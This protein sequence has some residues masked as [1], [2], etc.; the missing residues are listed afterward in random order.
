META[1]SWSFSTG[2]LAPSERAAALHSLRE[3]G[4]LPLEPLPGWQAHADLE[5]WSLPGIR[6]LLGTLGGLRQIGRSNSLAVGD[7]VFLGVNLTGVSTIGHLGRELTLQSGDA[8]LLSCAEGFEAHRPTPMH[9]LGLRMPHKALAPLAANLDDA[10]MRLIPSRS[11]SLRLLTN[12]LRLIGTEPTLDFPELGRAKAA[13]V[14]DLLA[15]SIGASRDA[16]AAA[17]DRVVR[18]ARL[19]AIKA[20][21]VRNLG[22]C[23][24][25]VSVVAARQGVTPRYIHKLFASEGVTFSEFVLIRRLAVAHR[26][27]TDRRLAWRSIASVAFDSG[28]ADLSYFNRTFKRTYNATPSEVRSQASG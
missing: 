10:V 21:V 18:A 25:T 9:F 8:V 13:H 5:M 22:D 12:Y 6:I 1:Q 4:I 23:G 26:A 14:L 16:M 24:L 7:E 2:G 15:L 27:L 11:S 19:R 17:Q 20:D 3:R 28:F